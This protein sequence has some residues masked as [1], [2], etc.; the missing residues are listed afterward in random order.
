MN[1]ADT[2][3]R[4]LTIA[5]CAGEASGDALGAHLIAA[6]KAHRP[7]AQFVGIGGPR[8]KAEGMDSFYD[9]E[10]LAVRGLTEVFK[11]LPEIM[12]IR[13]GLIHRL[14]NI[15]PDVFVGIDAPD[16]NL[17]VAEKLK[18]AGIP[19]VH[20]VSPSVWAWRRGRVKKI[21]RQT[22][23]VLCLFPMEPDLYRQAGGQAQFVGHPL[24]QTLPLHADKARAREQLRINQNIPVF[25]L[26]PGSRV[27][28][29]EYMLPLFLHA[30]RLIWQ[31]HENARFLLPLATRA[32]WQLAQII[33][34][35][36]E[37][38]DL[39]VQPIRAHADMASTAADAVLV[40]SGTATLE[41]ALCKC[42]MVISYRIS[43]LTYMWVKRLIKVPYVGLP[44]ILLNKA[45]APELLQNDATPQK[46]ADAVCHWYQSPQEVSALQNDFLKLH[47]SLRKDTAALAAEAV[48]AH[49]KA[50][51]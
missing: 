34:Q 38:Y 37:F 28:E 46:L 7:D 11:R 4:P 33:L 9:Q 17:G 23:E 43:P 21:V 20:Y 5:L 19:T 42:P 51:L 10:R 12:R 49:T 25:V 27:S 41:V 45:V 26:M 48:L 35:Q 40:A 1:L 14:T 22:D 36:N 24:A 31:Q 47:E 39:P 50:R 8:M 6:I 13:R 16:F 18:A 2:S 15:H 29:I 3:N 30:A 32:T 44:N